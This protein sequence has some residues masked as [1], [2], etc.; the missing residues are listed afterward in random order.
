MPEEL[1]HAEGS[2][3]HYC[4]A[5]DANGCF[6]LFTLY[7]RSGEELAQQTR[8]AAIGEGWRLDRGDFCPEHTEMS[9]WKDGRP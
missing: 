4:I 9:F 6:N 5:C 3:G 8:A 2:P 7:G 1:P